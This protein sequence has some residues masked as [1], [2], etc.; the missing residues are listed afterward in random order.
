VCFCVVAFILQDVL[1]FH[2]CLLDGHGACELNYTHKDF[3]INAL[4]IQTAIRRN[5]GIIIDTT[6]STT[7]T[8]FLAVCAPNRDLW[9][10]LGP[11][12]VI[13]SP[14]LDEY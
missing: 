5:N 11:D 3:L 6:S 4:L 10:W 7:T 14:S 2:I 8:T 9:W 13:S 1:V 12:N